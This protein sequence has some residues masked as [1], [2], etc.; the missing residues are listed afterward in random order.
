MRLFQTLLVLALQEIVSEACVPHDAVC[1]REFRPV[2]AAGVTYANECLAR[3]ACHGDDALPGACADGKAKSDRRTTSLPEYLLVGGVPIGGGPASN[4]A[5]GGHYTTSSSAEKSEAGQEPDAECTGG[6]V[7]HECGSRCTRTCDSPTPMPC[8]LVCVPRCE[9][10][11]EKPVWHEGACIE[12][13]ECPPEEKAAEPLPGLQGKAAPAPLL[14][15]GVLSLGEPEV[16]P[17]SKAYRLATLGLAE[18]QSKVCSASNSLG[19]AKLQGA[20][21]ERVLSASTQ[22]VAG[23]NS[24]V[25]AQTSVGN[26]ELAFFEQP[27]TQTLQL[28][29]ASLSTAVGDVS[30]ALEVADLIDQP[31]ALD[32]NDLSPAA[33]PTATAEGAADLSG[34]SSVPTPPAEKAA[35]MVLASGF[36]SYPRTAPPGAKPEPSETGT[37]AFGASKQDAPPGMRSA[38]RRMLDLA[39]VSAALSGLVFLALRAA[40]R[41]AWAGPRNKEPPPPA[42]SRVAAQL[43]SG[44]ASR[45]GAN[46]RASQIELV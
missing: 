31:L 12:A 38:T 15:G 18:L 45:F 17:G 39:L 27:W 8:I 33:A 7:W 21:V 22:V 35:A 46:A 2:C 41:P 44:R 29:Q 28:T 6:Q 16:A 30:E 40:P 43:A 42:A 34:E 25:V 3:A 23:L 4:A 24:R 20:S 26:L 13:E 5:F 19:C 36:S 37:A 1:T 11:A 14:P 9:C 32:L 10:P